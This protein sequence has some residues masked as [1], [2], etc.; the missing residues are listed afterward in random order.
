MSEKLLS[1]ENYFLI[2]HLAV[3]IRKC[4]NSQDITDFFSEQSL[5]LGKQLVKRKIFLPLVFF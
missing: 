5:G 2:S 1:I 3:S 4:S